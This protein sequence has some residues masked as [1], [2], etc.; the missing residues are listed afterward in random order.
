MVPVGPCNR[1]IYVCTALYSFK[2]IHAINFEASFLYQ[3]NSYS[4]NPC[5]VFSSQPSDR[6]LACDC[7]RALEAKR[8]STRIFLAFL[9]YFKAARHRLHV[10]VCVSTN[11][12]SFIQILTQIQTANREVHLCT[13]D[14]PACM[15]DKRLGFRISVSA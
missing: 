4:I 1:P 2:E 8:A 15:Y 13:P 12:H 11:L 5:I 3:M 7:S 14:P 6:R 9:P 10:H